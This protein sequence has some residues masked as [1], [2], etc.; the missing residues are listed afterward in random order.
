MEVLLC[1]YI[2]ASDHLQEGG[3]ARSSTASGRFS[4]AGG[5][6]GD[7]GAG[8]GVDIMASSEWPGLAVDDVLLPPGQCRTI[9][10]QFL[11]DSTLTVQQV[12]L[13]RLLA[14]SQPLRKH[15]T[16]LMGLCLMFCAHGSEERKQCA[17]RLRET[18]ATCR[19]STS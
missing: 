11:S 13:S 14:P 15:V 18:T 6:G 8:G 1:S 7:V 4:H 9:W 5:N 19:G 2:A 10:R 12:L 17:W 16:S 3:S